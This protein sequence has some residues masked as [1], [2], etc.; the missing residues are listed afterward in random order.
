[1]TKTEA[2]MLMNPVALMAEM[3]RISWESQMVIAMRMAGMMGFWPTSRGET[4]RMVAEKQTAAQASVRAA[5]R[6]VAKGATPDQVMSAALKPIGRRTHSNARR[7]SRG[8]G[9]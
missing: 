2:K 7:L 5:I 8:W 6:A 9:K 3:A 4:H 1:M